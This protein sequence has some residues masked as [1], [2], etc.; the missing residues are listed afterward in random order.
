M[1]ILESLN[2]AVKTYLN[3]SHPKCLIFPEDLETKQVEEDRFSTILH[4]QG[5]PRPD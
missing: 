2:E 4:R 1:N 5:T 3:T